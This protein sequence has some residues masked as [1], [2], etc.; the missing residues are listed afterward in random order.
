M[1][2][3][4][5][6]DRPEAPLLHDSDFRA[7]LNLGET[8][9]GGFF[10]YEAESER[11][12]YKNRATLDICGC[13]SDEEFTRLYGDTFRGLVYPDD[14]ERITQSIGE[15]I[16]SS[17]SKLDTVQ[18]R[19]TRADGEIRWIDDY[20]RFATIEGIGA[21]YYVFIWDVTER[22]AA[23]EEKMR[24]S[25]ELDR[26]KK[27]NEIR[28]R[29]IFNLSHDIRTPMNAIVGFSDLA[30]KNAN[31]PVKLSGYLRHIKRSSGIMLAI[32]DDMLEMSDVGGGRVTIRENTADVT[33]QIAA[34]CDVISVAAEKKGVTVACDVD[35]PDVKVT[36]D[37]NRFRR[38]LGNILE[39]AVK[40]TP[41]GGKATV[42]A[43]AGAESA[44]G[45]IRYEFSVTDTGIG[46]SED[47]V[48]KMF[49]PFER[50]STSTE[51]GNTGTGLGLS[52][53]RSI[54]GM[55]GGTV[56]AE[57][58]KG[59]GTT[60]SF[61][62]PLRRA[63]A[64]EGASGIAEEVVSDGGGHI[65]VVEDIDLNRELVVDVLE[66]EGFSVT[67]VADGCD[68]V[69][70]FRDSEPGTFDLVLMDIQM[71]VMNGYE[72]T[73]AIRA[74]PRDDAKDIPIVALSANKTEDD[75]KRSFECGM[76]DH[77]AKPFDAD[78]LVDT[79]RRMIKR[80]EENG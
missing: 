22:R 80:R 44:S 14:Y 12:I 28:N 23:D 38:V 32:I 40:F 55:M 31:D 54:V 66:A 33:E 56:S 21:V 45:Y 67:G 74:L 36:L 41:P 11:I 10:I 4:N 19:I 72:A 20:G 53:V 52:I 70:V 7:L 25:L 57:S 65:L 60:V 78:R 58:R 35:L 13:R 29:F 27:Q 1:T 59:E 34:V 43:R 47:F 77:I 46:M 61:D 18:Y 39:N 24:V 26:E 79:I 6:P 63:D 15:Q 9:P 62:L 69:A 42:R 3:G 68:A 2:N 71:P 48:G 49:Q 16:E 75:R 64:P 76:N 73:R 17:E 8:V 30:L 50:E 37:E 5:P 51:S